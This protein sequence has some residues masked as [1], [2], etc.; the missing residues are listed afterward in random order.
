MNL[1]LGMIVEREYCRWFSVEHPFE[2]LSTY[3][4]VRLLLNKNG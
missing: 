3:F 1:E 4:A 2:V